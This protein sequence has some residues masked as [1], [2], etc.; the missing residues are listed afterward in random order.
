MDDIQAILLDDETDAIANT[1]S[2]IE[3]FTEG[4]EVVATFNDPIRA[5]EK[6]PKLSFDVLFLDIQM[7]RLNGF[8][9]LQALKEVKFQVVFIT[10]HE[11]YALR[12]F[13]ANALD[14]IL[15]P[16]N[17]QELRK[18]INHLRK[19][20]SF[21]LNNSEFG[22]SYDRSLANFFDAFGSNGSFQRTISIK[23]VDS[24]IKVVNIKDIVRI[25]STSQGAA[26]HLND[27]QQLLSGMTLSECETILDPALFIRSHFSHI[28]NK[29]Y[30][31]EVN[32]R[33]TGVLVLKDGAEVPVSARR[34]NKV[35][36]YFQ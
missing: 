26:I 9:F 5:L 25:I 8:E 29:E 7:P 14:Y 11:E 4:V 15:K 28:V 24:R 18:T 12:A 27:G 10:A 34:K 17:T 2:I 35:L 36:Q 13:R 31:G 3:N 16:I 6:L 20:K 22:L 33:R 23:S 30:V 32:T 1:L 21:I 19:I